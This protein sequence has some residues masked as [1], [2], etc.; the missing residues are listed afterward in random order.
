VV[1]PGSTLFTDEAEK[2]TSVLPA[3]IIDP[4]PIRIRPL[5]DYGRVACVRATKYRE[6]GG[7]GEGN[8]PVA[9]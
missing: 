4:N 3:S 5:T 2:Y 6:E 7:E 8:G 1:L 9:T